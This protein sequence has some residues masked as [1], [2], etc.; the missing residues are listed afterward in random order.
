MKKDKALKLA[1][2]GNK[3]THKYYLNNEWFYIGNQG[4]V[5]YEDGI[6]TDLEEFLKWHSEDIWDDGYELWL[7]EK[8][9]DP[10]PCP[11]CQGCGCTTCGGS[12][13]I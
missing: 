13:Y 2:E 1:R 8:K 10:Q 7:Q 4:Q 11:N 5:V 12:G 3:I 9:E 6:E